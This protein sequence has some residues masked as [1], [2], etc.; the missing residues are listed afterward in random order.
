MWPG[1]SLLGFFRWLCSW[2]SASVHQYQIESRRQ[3]FAWSRKEYLYCFAGQRGSQWANALK[4]VCPNL[5][6]LVRSFIVMIQRAGHDQLMDSLLTG[7]WWGKWESASSTSWFQPVWGLCACGQHT[8]STWWGFQ[9][10]QDSSKVLLC[11]SLEGEPG[12]CP[13]VVLLFLDCSSL[14]SAFPPFPD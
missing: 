10:L 3:S 5:Q 4:T 11:I 2:N 6:G 9:Y 8:S 7:W 14:V 12:P 1:Y 13:K